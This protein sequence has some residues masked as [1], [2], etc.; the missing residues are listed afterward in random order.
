MRGVCFLAKNLTKGYGSTLLALRAGW[1]GVK[2]PGHLN[3]HPTIVTYQA[4]VFRLG[5][6]FQKVDSS[7]EGAVFVRQHLA[8]CLETITARPQDVVECPRHVLFPTF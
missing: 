7:E 8:L 5:V 1:A 3:G 2:F 4:A 6:A